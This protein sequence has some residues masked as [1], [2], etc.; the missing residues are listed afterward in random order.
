MEGK[1]NVGDTIQCN[2]GPLEGREFQ[3][4]FKDAYSYILVSCNDGSVKRYMRLSADK[5]RSK[6]VFPVH[7]VDVSLDEFYSVIGGEE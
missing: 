1:F 5:C 4:I 6:F 2:K 7:S 3:V